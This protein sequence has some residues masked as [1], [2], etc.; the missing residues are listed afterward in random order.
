VGGTYQVTFDLSGN[1]D[2][3]PVGDSLWSPSLKDVLV[4]ATGALPQHFTFDTSAAVS[5]TLSNMLWQSHTYT[6]KATSAGTAL[7]FA[8]QIVGA[9]GPALDNVSVVETAPPPPTDK[10]QCKDN[11][12][13]TLVDDQG[14]HF[15]NQGDCV[16]YVATKGK[17]KAAGGH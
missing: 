11:G 8:S 6:F 13:K 12:W 14:N 5:N 1:P 7:S 3:R 2:G 17:N 10:E 15:K 16:S 9:F 4:S